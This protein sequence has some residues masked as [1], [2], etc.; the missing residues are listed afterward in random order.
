MHGVG[1]DYV[2]FNCLTEE[3]KNPQALAVRLSKRRFSIGSDGVILICKSKIADAKMRIFNADGSEGKT[4]GN[5]IRCVAKWLYDFKKVD[6]KELK[7]ETLS[8]VKRLWVNVGEDGKVDRV[9][10]D[11]GRANFSFEAIPA[12]FSG[13][14]ITQK[15]LF[16]LGKEYKVTCVSMGNP[17]CV[18]FAPAPEPFEKIGRAFET[19]PIFPEGI[20]TEFATKNQDGSFS[21]RVWERGSGE[22]LACGTGACAVAAAAVKNGYAKAGQDIKILLKGGIITVNYTEERVFM[23]GSAVLSYTGVVEI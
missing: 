8:G 15:T 3:L 23:T 9:K 2:Y 1:N 6:R 17:H 20:N 10:A 13:E 14:N 5:G 7:I 11:M 18:V 4:C 19:H 16:V 21:V 22:T 12:L